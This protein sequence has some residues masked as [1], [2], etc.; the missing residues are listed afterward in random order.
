MAGRSTDTDRAFADAWAA[1][2]EVDGWLSEGQARML[3]DGVRSLDPPATVVEIGSYRGRSAIVLGSGARPGVN[4]VAIDPHAGNDRG[5]TQIRG[6]AEEGR[7]D[8]DAF[9]TNLDRAGVLD[10]VRHVDRMSQMA[11]DDVEGPVDLLYVDGAHR[12]RPARADIA[13]WGARLGP[14]GQLLIHDAWN[15]VGVTGAQL[16]LLVFG[17]RFR[18][19]GRVRSMAAYRREDITGAARLANTL[20]QLWTLGYSVRLQL[21][22]VALVLRLR[23]LARLLGLPK[24]DAWPY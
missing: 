6:S 13:G 17:S 21:I 15:A 20:R 9:V 16:R 24:A 22:K 3:W 12:Y 11:F 14:G 4:V 18:Y 23:F 19:L 10:R 5:P 2:S 7:A 1:A 8:H